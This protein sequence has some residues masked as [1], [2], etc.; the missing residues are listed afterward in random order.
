[1]APYINL[2]EWGQYQPEQQAVLLDAV[3]EPLV[4]LAD[5][6]DATTY[7]FGTDVTI[8][9]DLQQAVLGESSARM[10]LE[11]FLSEWPQWDKT[12]PDALRADLKAMMKALKPL[13][14][15]QVMFPIRTATTG[16]TSGADLATALWLLGTQRVQHRVE[17]A[18][19]YCPVA[20]A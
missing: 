5:I 10:V 6:T 18:L 16:R 12:N 2:M 9:N 7:F 15:K 3:R 1:M 20:T 11:Q 8:P 14:P 19:A 17:Q 4:T 13:K